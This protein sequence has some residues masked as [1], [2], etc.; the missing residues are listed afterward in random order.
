MLDFVDKNVVCSSVMDEQRSN[1]IA[2]CYGIAACPK[3]VGFKIDFDDMIILDSAFQKVVLE[4]SE[5]KKAFAAPSDACKDFDE[6]VLLCGDE[7]VQKLWPHNDGMFFHL[8]SPLFS[9]GLLQKLKTRRLYQISLVVAT[10]AFNFCKELQKMKVT[11]G[12]HL[13][14]GDGRIRDALYI[15]SVPKGQVKGA[16]LCAT[17]KSTLLTR[18]FGSS[19]PVHRPSFRRNGRIR[20]D[21]ISTRQKLLARP[22]LFRQYQNSGNAGMVKTKP[23]QAIEWYGSLT[24][25]QRIAPSFFCRERNK[26][27]RKEKKNGIDKSSDRT[28]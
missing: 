18:H 9:F 2:K 25:R 21:G 19:A 4:E 28:N 10:G 24:T 5:Q 8:Y 16:N 13:R 11:A 23:A 27:K 1:G 17:G 3:G 6:I 7:T 14:R 20:R 26:G 15:T 12:A 22:N